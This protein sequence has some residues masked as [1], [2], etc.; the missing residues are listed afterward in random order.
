M[1][2]TDSLCDIRDIKVKVNSLVNK[3]VNK[4][5]NKVRSKSK[6]NQEIS[7]SYKKSQKNAKIKKT[8][9]RSRSKKKE[10]P[11]YVQV[12]SS[13]ICEVDGSN[14]FNKITIK[15][16]C[17]K[18]K[19]NF[20]NQELESKDIKLNIDIL[21]ATRPETKIKKISAHANYDDQQSDYVIENNTILNE[22]KKKSNKKT[23][24]SVKLPQSS[25]EKLPKN[26]SKK[27]TQEASSIK[28]SFENEVNLPENEE[29]QDLD[30]VK[31][32]NN[33]KKSSNL[34]NPKEN[35][36]FTNQENK[37]VCFF[38][39]FHHFILFIFLKIQFILN[40]HL[41]SMK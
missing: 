17:K 40:S 33:K 8:I 31:Y 16:P 13:L 30:E 34:S 6:N 3:S 22:S 25:M 7:N 18:E 41:F 4:E 2:L 5:N 36:F 39:K 21:L 12:E 1:N 29:N 37:K 28:K 32:S 26:L 19:I 10:D 14:P 23:S 27:K 20:S 9:S 38:F 15:T 35:S 11:N 24:Q